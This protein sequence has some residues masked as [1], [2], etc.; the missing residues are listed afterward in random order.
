MPILWTPKLAVGVPQID[1]EH[2]ELFGRVNRLLDAMAQAKAKEELQPLLAFLADYV[3]TH[4]GGEQRLMQQ[5]R[6]PEAAEHL[7]QHAFFVAEFKVLAAEV[8]KGGPTA[9][10]TIKLNKLLC[11]WLRDHVGSTDR[12]FGEFLRSAGPTARA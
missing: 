10:V 9:L 5:H 11:D 1:E 12:R 6:Y 4:F 3:T 2:Q 8:Q 7:S